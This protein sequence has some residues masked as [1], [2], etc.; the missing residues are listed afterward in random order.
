MIALLL[1]L[2]PFVDAFWARDLGALHRELMEEPS[3]AQHA[4]FDDLLRL[5][6]CDKLET[7]GAPDPLRALVRAEEARRGAP[8][9]L[10][11]DVLRESFF[12]RAVTNPGEDKALRW[13]DEEERWP[14][15]VLLVE[16]LRWSCAKA[17]NGAGALA[18]LTPELLRSLP[19][20]P[21]ARVAYERAVLLWRKGSLE[22]AAA[23]EVAKL[24]PELR[25]AARFLRLEAKL[26][27]PEDWIALA[28]D[29]PDLAVRTRATAEL[30]RQRR[31]QDVLPITDK[32][33]TPKEPARAEMVRSML[34]ARAV[35]LQALGREQEM[36]D[37]LF[38]AQSLPG[39][40]QGRDAMRA[41]AMSTLARQP[42]DPAALERFSGL[43]GLD[44]AWVEL[45][46]RALGAGNVR[47][48]RDAARHLQQIRDP[49]WRAAGLALDGE[50]AWV[51][52]E[53]GATRAAFD[54][55]FAPGWRNAE[56]E[57]RDLAALQLAHAMVLTE[58]ERGQSRAQLEAQLKWL[59]ERL[60]ARDA[61][62][63]E[64]LLFSLRDV[65]PDRGEQPVALGLLDVVRPP[66]PPE[67]PAVVAELPEPRSL[68]AIPAPDGT[69]KDWFDSRGA[70]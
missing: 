31:Y 23:I 65:P 45:A 8:A 29:W 32:V 2:A 37:A 14:G 42:A 13:L 61:A 68:L 66:E 50:I 35:A 63:V 58:V 24:A 47:T 64:A 9:T 49:R 40:I 17:P 11:Q 59:R 34:W 44:A 19:P 3:G 15:E 22:G 41:M 56:R 21:A 62:Q 28:A 18:L 25:P 5:T 10:W 38:R 27:P 48:A 6:T 26:D 46:R 43:A 54:Q 30:L 7:P 67:T 16:P 70:P 60:S 51:T 52:G 53:T 4:L 12:R 1:V 39:S 57:P 69:L 33:E 36:L 55:L 20:E